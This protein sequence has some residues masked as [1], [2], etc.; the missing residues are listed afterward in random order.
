MDLPILTETEVTLL[1]RRGL[2]VHL[3]PDALATRTALY[4][5]QPQS[6]LWHRLEGGLQLTHVTTQDGR[7]FRW[8]QS[9]YRFVPCAC[10]QCLSTDTDDEP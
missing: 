6:G 5:R 1:A 2:G 3:T 8:Q 10:P 7:G 9:A 4:E